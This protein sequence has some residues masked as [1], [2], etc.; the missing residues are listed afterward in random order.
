MELQNSKSWQYFEQPTEEQLDAFFEG[1]PASTSGVPDGKL[2]AKRALPF[3]LGRLEKL[4][5]TKGFAVGTEFSLADALI[6]NTF[7]EILK[8]NE[9]H[10]KVP[11]FRREPFG[12]AARMAAEFAPILGG[13]PAART[14]PALAESTLRIE[15]IPCL[16]LLLLPQPTNQ[17]TTQPNAESASTQG[18]QVVVF[19]SG[20]V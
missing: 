9:A 17:P 13:A 8:D 6:Y 15:S 11:Q 16:L 10:E 2:R 3:Y 4:V 1:G 5:G 14:A 7:G 19:S 18:E 20:V 12:D